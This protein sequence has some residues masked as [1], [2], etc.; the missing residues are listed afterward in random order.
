[1]EKICRKCL[2]RELDPEGLYRSIS[3][4]IALLPEEERTAPEEYARRLDI[5]RRCESLVSGTC[6]QC[7][8]YAELRAAKARE[9]CAAGSW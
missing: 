6:M 3:E 2:L 1:M 9:R 5:C 7:G 8:C 4:R